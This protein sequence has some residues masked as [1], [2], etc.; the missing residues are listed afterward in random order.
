M[1]EYVQITTTTGKRHDAEQ[2]ASELVSRKFAACAQV[3]GPVVS[4]FR[5]QGKIETAE[6]WTCTI[7][8]TAAQLVNIQ[9]LFKE[10]HPYEVPEL[11]ATPIIDGSPAYLK[12]VDEE[13]K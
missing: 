4:T 11:I 7:K 6:E 2:I 3:S 10:I 13:T 5:W 1:A 9:Q 12:W 8:T